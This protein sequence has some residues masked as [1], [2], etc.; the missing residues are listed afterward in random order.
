MGGDVFSEGGHQSTGNEA[1][2]DN[3]SDIHG[4][5][6]G[7][8]SNH[9]KEGSNVATSKFKRVKNS[10]KHRGSGKSKSPVGLE[11]PRKRFREGSDPLDID[12]FIFN[13]NSSP[14]QNE[15]CEGSP[16]EYLT[17]DLNKQNFVEEDGTRDGL[18]GVENMDNLVKVPSMNVEFR[19]EVDNTLNF[20]SVLGVVNI[21]EFEDNVVKAINDEGFQSVD[22]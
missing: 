4:N 22:K 18:G 15:G 9:L 14:T 5:I 13:V 20:A 7:I 16:V 10:R 19:E 12:R 2:N 1:L 8:F 21:N 17:P 3:E 6:Q 11:R